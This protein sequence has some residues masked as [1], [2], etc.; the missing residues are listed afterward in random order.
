MDDA[1]SGKNVLNALCICKVNNQNHQFQLCLIK[2]EKRK[3]YSSRHERVK[4]CEHW[5]TGIPM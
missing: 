4:D 1:E 5:E 2:F 3:T